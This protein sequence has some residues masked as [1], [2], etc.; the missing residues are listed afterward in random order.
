LSPLSIKYTKGIQYNAGITGRPDSLKSLIADVKSSTRG[1]KTSDKDLISLFRFHPILLKAASMDLVGRVS[2]TPLKG[3]V[4]VLFLTSDHSGEVA[5]KNERAVSNN[6]NK[7]RSPL[8][9]DPE[10]IPCFTRRQSVFILIGK[11]IGNPAKEER[12]RLP[13]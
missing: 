7:T 8:D 5:L 12:E 4:I 6:L 13:L 9:N 2:Q 3:S 1:L 10:A 11:H